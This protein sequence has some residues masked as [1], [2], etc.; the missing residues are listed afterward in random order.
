MATRVPIFTYHSIDDSGSVISTSPCRFREQMQILNERSFEIIS[1][2]TLINRLRD[3]QH[4]SN[5]TAVIT[6]DDGFK[7]F[8]SVAYRTLMNHGFTATVFLVPG[9]FGKNNQ[10][11][12]QL[13]GVPVLDLLNWEEVREM[14]D[15]GIDFG[16]HGMNHTVLP[17]LT[18]AEAR[19][20]IVQSKSIIQRYLKKDVRV[21]SYPYGIT[22]KAILEIVCEE[23]QGACGTRMNF[24]KSDSNIYELPRIDMFYF[25][26]NARFRFIGASRFLYFV[27]LR[28]ILRSLKGQ[29]TRLVEYR[30]ERG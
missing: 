10:W 13:K 22:N 9:Y 8:Y 3:N 18:L 29:Y 26:D 5:R 7:N 24:V 20:E 30:H 27:K 6:F 23:F 14:A 25:S 15:N 4:I 21:F 2:T 17:K 16:A 1:L 28:G 12:G 11:R 19:E